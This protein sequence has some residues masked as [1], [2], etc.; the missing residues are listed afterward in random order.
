MTEGF[1]TFVF[2]FAM[3]VMV[4]LLSVG[5]NAAVWNIK[6]PRPIE[7]RDHRH[8]YPLELL[9]LALSK[10]GVNYELNASDR[11]LVS[12]KAVRQLRENREVNVVWTMTDLN[13]E[14][15]LLPI[16]IPLA[17]GLIGLRVFMTRQDKIA[18]IGD[19]SQLS[20]LHKLKVIQGADWPDTKILQAN[21]FHIFPIGQFTEG[22]DALVAM[23]GD[24][25]PRSVIEVEAELNIRG[26]D[27]D[28]VLEPTFALYYPTAM[29][30]FVNKSNPTLARLIETGMERAI[31]DG[32]FEQLFQQTYADTLARLNIDKRTVFTLENPLLSND[33]PLDIQNYWFVPPNAK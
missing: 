33:T 14:D 22:F 5:A 12:S 25:Y 10:T 16:R 27:P 13:R 4:A 6:Y 21:G 28:I 1:A 24:I 15:E 8:E 30:F 31:A 20:D 23:Q 19:M 3:G 18:D 2:R 26:L 11:I 9:K 7:E 32:S 17:K 29:Y